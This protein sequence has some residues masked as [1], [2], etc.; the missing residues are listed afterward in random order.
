MLCVCV[1]ECSRKL[2]NKSVN[3]QSSGGTWLRTSAGR[4]LPRA[5]CCSTTLM[6]P[7]GRCPSSSWKE[8]KQTCATTSWTATWWTGTWARKWHTTGEL[9]GFEPRTYPVGEEQTHFTVKACV[10]LEAM[11]HSIRSVR[12]I[13][14]FK[15]RM[16]PLVGLKTESHPV[17][18]LFSRDNEKHQCWINWSGVKLNRKQPSSCT[19]NCEVNVRLVMLL[20][21][22]A[23]LKQ[24]SSG[25]QPD[26][27]LQP[28]WCAV[29]YRGQYIP[30]TE[31][32][33]IYSRG[34]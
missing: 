25:F 23:A 10:S 12:C 29:H 5:K 19:F 14:A 7:R 15:T 6:S 30:C 32:L 18:C 9:T 20:C 13:R 1:R 21:D 26:L 33:H 16:R 27:Q 17:S 24:Y 31:N 22:Y 8:P 3:P 11:L 34:Q 4:S 28:L 2:S